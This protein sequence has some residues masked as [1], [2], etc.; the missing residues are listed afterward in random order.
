M[1]IDLKGEGVE[2]GVRALTKIIKDWNFFAS[3][4][5]EKPLEVNFENI[6]LIPISDITFIG[7]EVQKFSA[8]QKKS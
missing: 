5:D 3:E 4:T 6:S 7:E 8:E 2:Q 1:G